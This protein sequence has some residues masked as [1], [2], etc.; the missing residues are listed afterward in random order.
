M[1]A[2][3]KLEKE[4]EEALLEIFRK[5]GTLKPPYVPTYLIRMLTSTNPRYYKGPVGTVTWLMIGKE[6]TGVGFHRLVK[7]GK[8]DWTIESLIQDPKWKS[9]FPEWVIANAKA[10]LDAFSK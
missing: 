9:L 4:L 10:R 8:L 6:R 1:A 5:C 7:E 3:S 2:I